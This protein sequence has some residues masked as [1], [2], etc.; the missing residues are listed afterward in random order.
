[1]SIAMRKIAE[2]YFHRKLTS[3]CKKNATKDFRSTICNDDIY[4]LLPVLQFGIDYC[5]YS[6]LFLKGRSIAAH[7]DQD[8]ISI[9][10]FKHAGAVFGLV[11]GELKLHVGLESID[12]VAGDYVFFDDSIMHSVHA[13]KTWYGIAVQCM[14]LDEVIK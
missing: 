11:S 13:Q 1:M 8:L 5:N 14:T 10:G 3:S 12:M 6:G 2:N 9:H 7:K 4:K